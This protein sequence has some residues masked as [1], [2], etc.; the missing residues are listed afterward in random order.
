MFIRTNAAPTAMMTCGV[1]DTPSGPSSSTARR[2]EVSGN[3]SKTT[4]IAPMPIPIDGAMPIPGSPPITMPSTPPIN[5]A[6]KTGP[7]RKALNDSQMKAR[8]QV[9]GMAA[10]GNDSAEFT[11]EIAEEAKGWAV[12]VKNRGL[13]AN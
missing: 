3:R 2:T 6:G 7:P 10:V 4:H 9:A 13:T 1:L 5:R 8:L 11:K 12:V